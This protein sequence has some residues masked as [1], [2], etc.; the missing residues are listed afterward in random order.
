MS[1]NFFNKSPI[2]NPRERERE[3]ERERVKPR[4]SRFVFNL[5]SGL[6]V[7][8]L[9]GVIVLAF[10]GPGTRTPGTGNPDFWIKTGT[11]IYYNPAGGG[12]VGIG[13]TGPGSPLE[14]NGVISSKASTQTGV[15][16]RTT[17]GDNTL[18]YFELLGGATGANWLIFTNRSN[19]AGAADTLAFYK[20]AGTP[21]V[22]MVINDAGNVGIGTASPGTKLEVAGTI[23]ATGDIY[24]TAWTSYLSESTIVGFST[25]ANYYLYYKKVG[26]M[27]FF[28]AD[29]QGTSNSTNFTFTMPYAANGTFYTLGNGIDNGTATVTLGLINNSNVMQCNKGS[30]DA[31][32]NNWTASGGKVI[33]LTGWYEAAN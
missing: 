32:H 9:V 2:K 28:N 10:T 3:R 22:K 13:T 26:K 21:G 15:Q 14:V 16:A 1:F 23:N 8:L 18:A 11:D 7:G 31:S 30:F 25:P 6:T 12:N 29:I 5:A 17:A 33:R 19:L 24:T 4:F 27:V 20:Q